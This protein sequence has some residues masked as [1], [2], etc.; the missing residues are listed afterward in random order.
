MYRPYLE[1]LDLTYTQ[2]IA[3]MAMWEKDNVSVK[4]LGERLLLDSGTL[5]PVLRKLESKGYVSRERSHDD[6][7]IVTLRV[8]EKGY[9]LRDQVSDIPAK[10]GGCIRLEP[11]EAMQLHELLWKL[12]CS[13]KG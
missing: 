6:E 4:D 3:M 1:P 12:M 2:Y 7:R 11:E 8:T 10:L 9:E 13:M 5:T